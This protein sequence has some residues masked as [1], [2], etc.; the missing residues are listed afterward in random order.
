MEAVH[1]HRLFAPADDFRLNQPPSHPELLE[2]LA[3]DFMRHG[4]DLKHTIR[5]IL[6]SRTYQLR[7]DPE[8]ED[9]FD[10]G[11]PKA[12]RYFRSPSLRRMACEQFLDSIRVAS[13]QRLAPEERVYLNKASTELTRAMGKPS[14]RT[15]VTTSRPDDAAVVQSLELLNGEEYNKLIYSAE[16]LKKLDGRPA[17]EVADQLYR[18]VLSRGATAGL[19]DCPPGDML[20]A[21]FTSPEFQYI[22]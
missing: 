11:K 19:A 5:L 4:Y 9:H 1:R 2:W 14:V 21:L 17:A 3:D 6:T 22:R 20:W 13:T 18:A 8:L 16:I 7:Y 15:E 12:A 10:V